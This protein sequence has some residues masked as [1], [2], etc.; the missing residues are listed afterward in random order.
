MFSVEIENLSTRDQSKIFK[1]LKNFKETAIY[2]DKNGH[3]LLKGNQPMI[4]MFMAMYAK[5]NFPKFTETLVTHFD[6]VNHRNWSVISDFKSN[7]V[8]IWQ[9]I[10]E[11]ENVPPVKAV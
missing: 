9:K 1:E 3:K 4:A 7:V 8:R 11:Y 5:E 10:A 6:K 2:K